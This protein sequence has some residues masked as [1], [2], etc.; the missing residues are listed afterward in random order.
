MLANLRDA[1]RRRPDALSLTD[2]LP[3]FVRNHAPARSLLTGRFLLMPQNAWP[4][5][6]T[7]PTRAELRRQVALRAATEVS[8]RRSL[9]V[10][11]ISGAIPRR[12]RSAS[13]GLH[14]VLDAA[15]DDLV[16]APG[17]EPDVPTPFLLCAGSIS[18]YRNLA[19]LV[20]AHRSYR[21]SGGGLS[22]VVAGGGAAR[23]EADLRA[24]V[25]GDPAVTYVG[26]QSRAGILALLRAS[27]AAVFPS[28]VEASPVALLE[29][30]VLAPRVAASGIVGHQ[31][32]VARNGADVQWF[33]PASV[34]GIAETLKLL[35]SAPA[36][37]PPAALASAAAREAAREAWSDDLVAAIGALVGGSR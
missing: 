17:A 26:P 13:N 8:M 22:L 30:L 20:A 16:A 21:A 24:R 23:S 10:L 32:L 3:L 35:E 11:R 14:N 33:D 36:T 31:E 18:S 7:S 29:A 37:E 9:G 19:R 25:A 28:L 6:W 15:F 5:C 27:H 4:W 2:G 34:E 1:A 12:G